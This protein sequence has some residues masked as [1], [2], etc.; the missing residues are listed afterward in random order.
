MPKLIEMVG[1]K[2]GRWTVLR[3]AKGARGHDTLWWSRCDC[4]VE[5]AVH[6]HSLRDGRSSNCGCETSVQRKLAQPGHGGRGTRL[7]RSWVGMRQ[8]CR[9]PKNPKYQRY[10]GRG[11]SVCPE[12]EE[13][14]AFREWAFLNG[15]R[16]DL[17]IDRI[18]N[19]AG[20]SPVNCRWASAKT[21]SR[22]RGFVALTSDGR[23]GPQVAEENGIPTTTYNNRRHEGWSIDEAATAPYGKLRAPRPRNSLGQFAS[24]S[25]TVPK[26]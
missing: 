2:F 11:I 3:R 23:P 17:S 15:Y 24:A 14:V 22:N 6:G 26:R 16:D 25:A 8:R 13:F 10:G 12:W 18:D 21:Q 7:Y 1:Q 20:Y 5:R 19:D 9:N 4:G